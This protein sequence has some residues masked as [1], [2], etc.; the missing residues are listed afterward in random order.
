MLT[1]RYVRS[2]II[3]CSRIKSRIQIPDAC[4]GLYYDGN[5]PSYCLQDRITRVDINLRPARS[6][7][8]RKTSRRNSFALKLTFGYRNDRHFYRALFSTLRRVAPREAS[9]FSPYTSA[10]SRG[11]PQRPQRA[12]PLPL[13]HLIFLGDNEGT[14]KCISDIP[15][16]VTGN[17]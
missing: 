14:C 17:E 11:G 8:Q 13:Y 9:F 16:L 10:G 1:I 6:A 4:A 5:P 12:I 7:T 15:A 2:V 3:P